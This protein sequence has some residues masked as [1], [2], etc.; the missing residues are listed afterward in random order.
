MPIYP[1]DL[2]DRTGRQVPR[3]EIAASSRKEN[4]VAFG[5]QESRCG[6]R[7]VLDVYRCQ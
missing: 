6:E 3:M 1:V 2:L 5:V 4:L 7:G